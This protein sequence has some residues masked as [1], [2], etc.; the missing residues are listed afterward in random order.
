MP[1]NQSTLT[2][3]MIDLDR[4]AARLVPTWMEV[5]MTGTPRENVDAIRVAACISRGRRRREAW[6]VAH[7]VA[8]VYG[9][10]LIS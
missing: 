4:V 8:D 10:G 1:P 6:K 5:P 9:L 3:E 2:S 7:L